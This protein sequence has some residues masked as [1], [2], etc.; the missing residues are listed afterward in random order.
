MSGGHFDYKQFEITRI[1]DEIEQL[2]EINGKKRVGRLESWEEPYHY[3]YPPEV[4]QKFK[5]AVLSLRVAQVYAQ[6][7]DWLVSGDDGEESFMR[8]LDE[9]LKD[10]E[11]RCEEW[12]KEK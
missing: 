3:E 6:R 8:R 2:I 5:E 10:I 12:I 4:I 11:K 9:D 7:V 1:S